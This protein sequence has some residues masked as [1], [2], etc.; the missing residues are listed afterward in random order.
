[1]C[2]FVCR[3]GNGSTRWPGKTWKNLVKKGIGSAREGS[4]VG[5]SG[6]RLRVRSQAVAADDHKVMFSQYRF[7]AY[8]C[9][10]SGG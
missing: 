9:V 1:M 6:G 2:Y 8:N 3:L 10:F 4:V 5:S 7:G